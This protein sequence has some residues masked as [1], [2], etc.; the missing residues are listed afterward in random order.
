[1]ATD[2]NEQTLKRGTIAG[3]GGAVLWVR[4][5]TITLSLAGI[6]IF[7][8]LS[9]YVNAF[10]RHFDE[11]VQAIAIAETERRVNERL[12]EAAQ[13]RTAEVVTHIAGAISPELGRDAD[14]YRAILAMGADD[15]IGEILVVACRLSCEDR[16]GAR[17]RLGGVLMRQVARH[18]G[19]IDR[20]ESIVVGEFD[21]VTAEFRGD[22]GKMALGNLIAFA[23][24]L[25]LTFIRGQ[26]ARQLLVVSVLMTVA[27]LAMFA[28]Y[29]FGQDWIRVIIFGD[30]LGWGYAIWLAVLGAVMLDIAVNRGRVM[31]LITG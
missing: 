13:S 30:Y 4:R 23:F 16:D 1:M 17:D 18:S 15:V 29:V 21:E 31:R 25:L 3:Q 11:T 22:V 5:V 2:D 10:P 19:A 27:T 28:L 12:E 14:R 7:G 9:V 24:A 6:A 26:S 8:A 20:L